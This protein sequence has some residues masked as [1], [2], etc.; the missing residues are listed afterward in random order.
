MMESIPDEILETD[1][2]LHALC[3]AIP[4][5]RYLNPLRADEARLAFLRGG[6]EPALE[7]APATWAEDAL[8]QL[9]RLRAPQ[10]APR[11]LFGGVEQMALLVRAPRK[12]GR[13]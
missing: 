9:S 6:G 5:S 2:T 13:F 4:F 8:E 1:R 7:Y 11:A 3:S 10:S 12:T